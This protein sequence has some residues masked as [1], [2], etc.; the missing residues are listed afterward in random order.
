VG[1]YFIGTLAGW[2]AASM[3]LRDQQ[4]Q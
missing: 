1:V 4:P 3:V 2:A